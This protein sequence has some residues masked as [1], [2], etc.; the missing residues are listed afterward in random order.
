[1]Y[2]LDKHLQKSAMLSGTRTTSALHSSAKASQEP[3]SSF[4]KVAKLS[5]PRSAAPHG[6]TQL[7]VPEELRKVVASIGQ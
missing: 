4:S 6:A 7:A 5:T 3:I 2:Q 1:M